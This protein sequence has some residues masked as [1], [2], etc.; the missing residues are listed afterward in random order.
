MGRPGVDVKI[1]DKII[2]IRALPCPLCGE[3]RVRNHDPKC[4]RSWQQGQI[5]SGKWDFEV[6]ER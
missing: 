3:G 2:N 6:E 4:E 1:G 5:R